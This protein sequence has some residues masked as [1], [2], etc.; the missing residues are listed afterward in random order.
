MR[1]FSATKMGR[2]SLEVTSSADGEPLAGSP[3]EFDVVPG[4]LS[5]CDCSAALA[6]TGSALLA[7]EEVCIDVDAKDEHS[8]K[9]PY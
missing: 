3:F 5:P 7:D 4:Q 2:Y 9:V 1:R 8:N 6:N